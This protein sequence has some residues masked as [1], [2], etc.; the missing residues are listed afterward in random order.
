MKQWIAKTGLA[1]MLAVLAA[2]G[3]S[4]GVP[5]PEVENQLEAGLVGAMA[6]GDLDLGFL[7]T[8]KLEVGWSGW[9]SRAKGM[10]VDPLN[11]EVV[12]V[13]TQFD[14]ATGNERIALTRVN[15]NGSLAGGFDG[16]N[17]MPG[18]PGNGKV[19]TDIPGV[20]EENV[21]A[22]AIDP[23]SR[24]IVVV[25]SVYNLNNRTDVFV[26]RYNPDG[27]LDASFG[28]AA[29]GIVVTSVS[30][31]DDWAAD[32]AIIASTTGDG[33]I[34]VAGGTDMNGS[35]D[36]LLMRYNANE[37]LS[38]FGSTGNGIVTT[39]FTSTDDSAVAV[40]ILSSG[41]IVLGGTNGDLDFALAQ[42]TPDGLLDVN[43]DGDLAMPGYP[44]NGK[45]T[46]RIAPLRG[47]DVA[48]DITV[49][50]QGRISMSG[51]TELSVG[52]YQFA[53]L[54]FN[55]NGTLDTGF[56]GDVGMVGYPGNGKVRLP[57]GSSAKAN[58]LMWDGSSRLVVVGES[59]GI[60]GTDKEFVVTR[61][62]N[63]GSLDTTFSANGA[64]AGIKHTD[65]SSTDEESAV[66]V[67]FAN[68]G[69]IWVAGT[70]SINSLVS[71]GLARYEN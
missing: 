3:S 58:A 9:E 48:T 38:S 22:V 2:C 10:A 23:Y 71:F 50:G 43:F 66:A 68:S 54:R 7:G 31:Y 62:N 21:R 4:V 69:K 52:T 27:T 63:N 28:S 65:W 55:S 35:D 47:I 59:F 56:D 39:S 12:I 15:P 18:F 19:T 46:A 64:L 8:G 41:N 51:W 57:I 60:N 16:D 33:K 36:F 37:N 14:P 70:V 61:F 45:V 20:S 49:G 42:Y 6:A 34:L 26:A 13:G 32:V 53:L 17:T 30:L 29:T 24:K 44:G 67:A 11:N 40:A 1:G 5:T 25:G